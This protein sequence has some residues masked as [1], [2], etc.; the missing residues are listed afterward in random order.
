MSLHRHD[1]KL[2]FTPR[3]GVSRGVKLRD[4]A[5]APQAAELDHHLHVSG[6]IHVRVRVVSALPTF[7]INCGEKKINKYCLY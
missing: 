5:N 7:L 6:R 4:H 2:T 3:L 1:L